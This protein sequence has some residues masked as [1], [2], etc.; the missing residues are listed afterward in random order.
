MKTYHI[1]NF[2][3]PWTQKKGWDLSGAET[4]DISELN[5]FIAEM[6]SNFWHV[7]IKNEL[8]VVMYKPHEIKIPWE[9]N[10]KN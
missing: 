6:E 4:N 10:L 2:G 5:S 8:S 1:D 3:H 7:W 9:E